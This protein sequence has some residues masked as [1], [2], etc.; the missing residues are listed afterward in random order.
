MKRYAHTEILDSFAFYHDRHIKTRKVGVLGTH[1]PLTSP[2]KHVKYLSVSTSEIYDDPGGSHNRRIT[3]SMLTVQFSVVF[4][5]I[6]ERRRIAHPS[7][8][9]QP[10]SR[11]LRHAFAN[12]HSPRYGLTMDSSSLS[13]RE[14]LAMKT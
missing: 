9:G 4:R 14:P 11:C 13:V 7:L 10:R 5:R 1:K 12:K 2:E 8:L 3:A 6:E